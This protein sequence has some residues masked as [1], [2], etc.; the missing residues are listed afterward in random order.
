MQLPSKPLNEAVA[1]PKGRNRLCSHILSY[2]RYMH[3]IHKQTDKVRNFIVT[4][5]KSVGLINNIL[6]PILW[7]WKSKAGHVADDVT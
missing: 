6:T 4:P 3:E 1:A 5:D 2:N 7:L